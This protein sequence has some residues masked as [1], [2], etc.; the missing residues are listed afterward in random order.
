MR[1]LASLSRLRLLNLRGTRVKGS[2]LGALNACRL[3]RLDLSDCPLDA[4]E[5][6]GLKGLVS[7]RELTIGGSV[8]GKLT[9]VSENELAFVAQLANLESLDLNGSELSPAGAELLARLPKLSRLNLTTE[10]AIR[11]LP[12]LMAIPSLRDLELYPWDPQAASTLSKAL[13]NCKLWDPT[14]RCLF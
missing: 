2:G 11:A 14:P 3:E 6:S 5:L 4:D 10:S 13:P 9:T 8:G 1:S 12:Q 7:L